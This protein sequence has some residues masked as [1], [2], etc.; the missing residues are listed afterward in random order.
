[1]NGEESDWNV[2]HKYL[3]VSREFDLITTVSSI[4][5]ERK[6][7]Y[8]LRHFFFR[9]YGDWCISRG[10]TISHNHWSQP[11]FTLC[12]SLTTL[13]Q[14]AC[15]Y[16]VYQQLP[17][18]FLV[19]ELYI[20]TFNW[21]TVYYFL[22]FIWISSSYKW[23]LPPLISF[24]YCPLV[25]SHSCWVLSLSKWP[26]V[27]TPQSSISKLIQPLV[28]WM[29]MKYIPITFVLTGSIL[30]IGNIFINVTEHSVQY[31]QPWEESIIGLISFTFSWSLVGA[32]HGLHK[33]SMWRWFV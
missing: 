4:H 31:E 24:Y 6:R 14:E 28:W 29:L 10:N 7:K 19:C 11:W 26:L 20:G 3:Q 30:K 23:V 2:F 8:P 15:K 16:F 9:Q 1:M 18:R 33:I 17:G 12:I 32:R 5:R 27:I 21:Y 13:R 25:L 22:V